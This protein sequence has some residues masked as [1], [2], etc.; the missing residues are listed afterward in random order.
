MGRSAPWNTRHQYIDR[1]SSAVR[2]EPLF[3][4]PVVA[5]LYAPLWED[6]PALHALLTRPWS[7][8][9]LGYLYYDALL[10]ARTRAM[11]KYLGACGV[12]LKE[13][14]EPP[15]RLDTPRK[16]FER[17]IR[18]W[19]CRPI[20][21]DPGAVVSP[22][23]A[24]VLVGSLCEMSTLCLK[25]KFFDLE[26]LLGRNREW[27]PI[28]QHG[29]YSI[30]RL[31]PDK[32]HYNHV[33]VAGRVADLYEIPGRY[34]A[35]NPGAVV[36]MVTPH[37]KNRRVVT[38]LDTDAPGGTGI[39]FVAMIEVAALMVGDVVQCYSAERYSAPR[40]LDPGMFLERGAVKSLFRP[41][42]STAVLLFQPGRI[43]FAEDLV[44]NRSR[45]SVSSRFSLGFGRPLVETDVP[46][47]S[48]LARRRSDPPSASIR[49]SEETRGGQ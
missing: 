15:E 26:E 49:H 35:C 3:G 36:T 17:Q 37:S 47:R 20:P 33:P 2:T 18:Y 43:A 10:G 13:C 21:E 46:A 6:G 7:S 48:L 44:A 42:G 25:G 45:P 30:H 4:D 39:G 19:E 14:V 29:D 28:F 5:F 32:Y 38:I 8:R 41:G 40:A 23:D 12:D 22:A 24:R 1:R 34:H 31:T 16:L 11:R 27:L 9:L